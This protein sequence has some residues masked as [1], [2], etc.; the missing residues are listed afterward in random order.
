MLLYRQKD[1]QRCPAPSRYMFVLP[2]MIYKCECESDCQLDLQE[3]KDL[4]HGKPKL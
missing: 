3:G 1:G 4:R 2:L